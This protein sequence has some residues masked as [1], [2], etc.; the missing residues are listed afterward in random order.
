VV[1]HS[2][3]LILDSGV[4]PHAIR[5]TVAWSDDAHPIVVEYNDEQLTKD[6]QN[7]LYALLQRIGQRDPTRLRAI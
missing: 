4:G 2:A 1:E 5:V 3:R 6:E 7:A